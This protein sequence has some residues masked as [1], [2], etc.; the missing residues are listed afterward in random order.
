M[1]HLFTRD[2]TNERT[3]RSLLWGHL[4]WY[5]LV[6]D[7]HLS[8]SFWRFI[9]FLSQLGSLYFSLHVYMLN[10]HHVGSMH[11]LSAT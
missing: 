10:M 9:F 4:H 5:T 3:G 2:S 1:D 7:S 11:Q 6:N 8:F